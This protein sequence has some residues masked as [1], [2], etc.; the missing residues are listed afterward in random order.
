M[1]KKEVHMFKNIVNDALY[2]CSTDCAKNDDQAMYGRGVLVGLV[3]G[4]MA[5]N[6]IFDDAIKNLS[7]CFSSTSPFFINKRCIP[8]CWLETFIKYFGDYIK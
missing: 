6:N 5:R 2:N 4:L 1:N 3:S 7:I 8:D